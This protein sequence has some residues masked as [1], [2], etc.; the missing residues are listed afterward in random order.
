MLDHLVGLHPALTTGEQIPR[1]GHGL[2]SKIHYDYFKQ[3]FL[4]ELQKVNIC[5]L[6]KK[7]NRYIIPFS[8]Y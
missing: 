6:K 5:L 7:T 2:Q 1:H 3:C 4:L 8:N